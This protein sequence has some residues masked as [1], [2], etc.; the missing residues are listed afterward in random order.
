MRLD[1][2][3]DLSHH[4]SVCVISKLLLYTIKKCV[5]TSTLGDFDCT[6]NENIS[7]LVGHSKYIIPMYYL[8]FIQSHKNL[9]ALLTNKRVRYLDKLFEELNKVSALLL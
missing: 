4:L 2:V 7:I 8:V 3:T 5:L 6:I 1:N 9:E